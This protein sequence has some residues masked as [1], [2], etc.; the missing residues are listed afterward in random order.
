MMQDTAMIAV[1]CDPIPS[2]RVTTE[3]GSVYEFSQGMMWV[4][5]VTEAN[6][7]RC[8][9]EWIRLCGSQISRGRGMKLW[10][11][12]VAEEGETLRLTTPVVS[13]EGLDA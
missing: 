1:R 6:A 7:L 11:T 3:S 13:I 2:L 8:D 4:R 9:G 12:G 5:R 10:L